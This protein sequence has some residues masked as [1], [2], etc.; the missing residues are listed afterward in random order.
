[1]TGSSR[2][3][4]GRLTSKIS[5]CLVPLSRVEDRDQPG[6]V[7]LLSI[8]GGTVSRGGHRRKGFM[9]SPSPDRVS[10]LRSTSG[11]FLCSTAPPAS[12]W[13]S[14]LGMLSSLS[15]LV[16]G[17]RLR[18][19]S[20]QIC[21]HRS[22]DRLEPSD[23]LWD[24]R[25]WLRG[26]RFSRGLSLNQVS[27]DL[28]FWSN[29]SD[30]GWGAHLGDRVV[31]GLWDQSEALL[32]VNARELLAVHHCLPHFQSFLSRTTVAMF[33]DSVTTVAY[34][35]KEGGTRSPALSTIVQEILRWA[36]SL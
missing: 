4:P 28:D 5:G 3:H 2:P 36:E 26:D 32:P 13:Q 35:R 11:K 30:V 34:L 27:P 6:E 19:R 17:V 14:L 9:A 15:H 8:S 22:W 24:I 7:Q 10:S 33:Y 20:L 31:S 21:L 25:W 1:M 12:L 16:P 29:A 23:C 18:M